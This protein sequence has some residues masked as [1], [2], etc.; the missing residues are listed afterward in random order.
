[1]SS[2][3][4]GVRAVHDLISDLSP[5]NKCRLETGINSHGSAGCRCIEDMRGMHVD[6]RTG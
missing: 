6:H 4:T 1:M 3:E 2:L 5:I